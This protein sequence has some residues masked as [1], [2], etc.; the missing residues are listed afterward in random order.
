MK[1]QINLIIVIFVIILMVI[2]FPKPK[3]YSYYKSESNLKEVEIIG[4]VNNP[5]IYLVPDGINLSYLINLSGGLRKD[6]DI[7]ELNLGVILSTNK[8]EI[9]KY[10]N[11]S[12]DVVVKKI[13]L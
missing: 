1:K 10:E 9:P 7:S 5:G 11:M 12:E 2:L 3:A 6:A 4:A 8:Y 13:S